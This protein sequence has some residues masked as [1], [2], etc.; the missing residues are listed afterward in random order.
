MMF[1]ICLQPVVLMEPPAQAVLMEHRAHREALVAPVC[2]EHQ[3]RLVHREHQARQEQ[4]ILME[5]LEP[6]VLQVR[7]AVP[8]LQAY[9]SDGWV[10][11]LITR[12]IRDILLVM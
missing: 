12:L 8:A 2:L 10:I 11:G 3:V 1:G 9:H 4:F 7:L 6:A 5:R